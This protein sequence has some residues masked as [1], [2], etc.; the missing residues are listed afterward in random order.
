MRKMEMKM[1]NKLSE[2]L[3]GFSSP[4]SFVRS[5]IHSSTH[6]LKLCVQRRET[7]TTVCSYIHH[8]VPF[9]FVIP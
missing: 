6:S 7:E 1:T 8:P 9:H 3:S 5:F 4:H 2:N